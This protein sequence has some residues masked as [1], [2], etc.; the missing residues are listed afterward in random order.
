M[1]VMDIT[2]ASHAFYTQPKCACQMGITCTSHVYHMQV[3]DTSHACHTDTSCGAHTY[4]TTLSFSPSCMIVQSLQVPHKD[5]MGRAYSYNILAF[6]II[7]T[8]ISHSWH[9]Y[10]TWPSHAFPIIPPLTCAQKFSWCILG[11]VSIGSPARDDTSVLWVHT[12]DVHCADAKFIVGHDSG[13]WIG[14]GGWE[15]Y[16]V[17]VESQTLLCSIS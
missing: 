5:T 13:T 4:T 15:I 11:S 1:V 14:W 6:T 10:V 16:L 7:G 8:W 12:I 9:M 17:T 2:W 3:T